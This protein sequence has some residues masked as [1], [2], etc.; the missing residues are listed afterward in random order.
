MDGKLYTLFT[1]SLVVRLSGVDIVH[2]FA[3]FDFSPV[4]TGGSLV[5]MLIVFSLWIVTHFSLG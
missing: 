1:S 2:S 4:R 5:V 3:S